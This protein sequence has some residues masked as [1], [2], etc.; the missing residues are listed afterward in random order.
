[1]IQL[2]EKPREV[3]PPV[4]GPERIEPPTHP[5]V[6]FLPEGLDRTHLRDRVGRPDR[7]LRGGVQL[8][9]AVSGPAT[10]QPPGL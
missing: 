8:A 10:V 7:C 4:L 2:R 3:T 5:A 1:M 6:P 9:A